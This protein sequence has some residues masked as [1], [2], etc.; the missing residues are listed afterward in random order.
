MSDLIYIGKDMKSFQ[1]STRFK[2]YDQVILNLDDNNYI[3]SP[4]VSLTNASVYESYGNGVYKFTFTESQNKWKTPT[5]TYVTTAQLAQNYGLT[6]HYPDVT[7]PKSGDVITVTK[8]TVNQ[9][10]TVTAEL[11]RSGSAL[12]ADCPL[13]KPSNRQTVA[14]N[15]LAKVYGFEYQ[16]FSAKGAYMN[17]AAEIGDAITAYNVF[18]GLFEQ[19]TIFDRLMLSNIGSAIS[20]EAEAEMQ[21]ENG[22]DR[23]YNRK[24]AETAAEFAILADRISSFVTNSQLQSVI[25][26]V[27]GEISA[28]VSE[29]GGN[30]NT[31]AWSLDTSGFYLY[32]NGA[33]VFKCDRSGITVVG[34]ATITGEVYASNIRSDAVNGYG[35]SFSGYGITPATIGT[36]VCEAGVVQS[37]GYA[38]VFHSATVSGTQVYPSLFKAG[39]I[40][41]VETVTARDVAVGTN[42]PYVTLKDH[43][44]SIIVDD[45]TGVVTFG[46]PYNSNTPPSF[47]IADTHTYR[48]GVAAATAAAAVASRT[49]IQTQSAQ[50]V[51]DYSTGFNCQ[52]TAN[53]LY[54]PSG[55]NYTYGRVEIKNAAGNVLKR[56]RI[57][58]PVGGSG[59]PTVSQ[60]GANGSLTH[61]GIITAT[62]TA[63]GQT[64]T[65]SY[66]I[67]LS[68]TQNDAS[69]VSMEVYHGSGANKVVL[70]TRSV[71]PQ[72]GSSTVSRFELNG[73]PGWRSYPTIGTANNY[74]IDVGVKALDSGGN[75]MGTGVLNFEVTS[76]LVEAAQWGAAN[77]GSCSGHVEITS[78]SGNSAFVKIYDSNWNAVPVGSS[79][80]GKW[81]TAGTS[82]TF[83]S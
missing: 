40:T 75:S 35:G 59:A 64:A 54:N 78:T 57:Q 27:A 39:Y 32:A 50:D 46:R 21:Y 3:S 15:L 13:V 70:A 79:S 28:K 45:T 5:E 74:Y 2:P 11:T 31:F 73:N 72:G 6:T 56:L 20:D 67:Y 60:S 63:N 65:D 62:A 24:L 43:Y 29:S 76:L 49:V 41:A 81:I 12:T 23:R 42:D 58:L 26:Q 48:D 36:D 47:R 51:N 7:N 66:D 82:E 8:T 4:S 55:T 53:D 16:P 52:F 19:E 68:V 9:S 17:P 69:A 71:T 34:D 18:S 37:L 80:V 1:K 10:S 33:L 61:Q 83:G 38:D 25:E 44:H 22:T 77:W 30:Q 14:D